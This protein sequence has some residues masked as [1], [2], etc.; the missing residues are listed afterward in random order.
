MTSAINKKRGN[1][2]TKAENKQS[3]NRKANLK[4]YSKQNKQTFNHKKIRKI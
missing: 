4:N 1:Q 3:V 2:S